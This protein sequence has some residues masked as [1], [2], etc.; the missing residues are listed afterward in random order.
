[1]LAGDLA[2]DEG[3]VRLTPPTATVGLLAQEPERRHDE[4][5]RQAVA[6]RTGVTAATEEYEAATAALA[7]EPEAAA[8]RY[9]H[10]LDTWLALGGADLDARIGETWAEL[11]LPDRLLDQPTATLSGGEAARASLAAVLLSRH[12]VLLL[13]EPTNDLDFAALDRLEAFVR[14][15]E[16][17][18]LL[19][20]HDRAFLER[21][22]SG[23]VEL[24]EHTRRATRYEGG[25]LGLPRGTG[26]RPPPRRGGLRP[27]RRRQVRP[28]STGPGASVSGPTRASP[29]AR[30]APGRTT[31]SSSATS[32][33]NAARTWP[34]RCVSPRRRCPGW[35]PTPPTNPGPAGSS[36]SRSPRPPAAGRWSP[37]WRGLSSRRGDF[38]LGPVD[39]EVGWADRVAIVGP[40]GSGKSTLLAALLGRLALDAGRQRLGPGVVV[41][42][43]DQGRGVLDHDAPL[44]DAF[45][46]AAGIDSTEE[47]RTLLAKFGLGAEHVLRPART[48][49][50]GER[51]RAGLALL[52]GRGVNCLVLDEPTNHLDLAALEQ[53]EQALET[54]GGT[55]LLVSH[56][57]QLLEA[58]TTTRTLHV[59]DGR[60]TET[61]LATTPAG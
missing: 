14:G 54:F 36:A 25:W 30:P 45:Q 50:P 42:E 6:R 26:H 4:T 47:A 33:T 43:V 52:Q 31:T 23:V 3:T 19:V 51:T 49:S 53:V 48:L 38:T 24:D 44:L 10:A 29:S 18:L 12:D 11:G 61:G 55:V 16:A 15:R 13:D 8:D 40:N 27:V 28:S 60:V 17:P 22:I 37:R 34:A 9:S 58:V 56:D 35:R 57:R 46:A 39:L 32:S 2:P 21:T 5:V 20:S 41:G 1:M 7:V 59:D